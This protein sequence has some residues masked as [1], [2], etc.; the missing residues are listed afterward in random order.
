MRFMPMLCLALM[1]GMSPAL[2]QGKTKIVLAHS[3]QQLSPPHSLASSLPQYFKFWDKENL[4]VEVITTA[5]S[6]AA[7]QL[8]I[9]GQADVVWANPLNV[10]VAIQR[11]APIKAVYSATRGDVFGVG[12][13]GKD[14]S[15][16][17]GKTIGVSSFASGTASYL[18]ALL[19]ESGLDPEKDVSIVE[20]GV[21][22]RAASAYA[23]KQVEA[24]SLWDEQF[25]VLEA[26]G[27]KFEHFVQD[28]R[29]DTAVSASII[30]RNEDLTKRRDIL[31]GIARGIAEGQAVMN[32]DPSI[33]VRAHWAVYPDSAP[34]TDRDKALREA[35]QVIEGRR[36]KNSRTAMGSNLYGEVP[37]A[38]VAK[39]QEYM[40]ATGQIQKKMDVINYSTNELIA[41]INKFDEASVVAAARKAFP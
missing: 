33:A 16:L 25:A 24:L 4:E 18:K 8:L 2:A 36:A 38:A 31:I 22:A 5:G 40:L 6:A 26:R 12:M 29:S 13:N 15:V 30:V 9:S 10:I 21:G 17:K 28:P 14:L 7:L 20:V 23:G 27:I 34:R 41:D 37:P 19:K 39:F 11:G 3:Q 35:V 32:A 1:A